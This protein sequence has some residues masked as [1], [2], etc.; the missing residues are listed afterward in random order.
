MKTLT[1]KVVFS[2]QIDV[3]VAAPALRVAPRPSCGKRA[4]VHP[5]LRGA[6][7]SGADGMIN[8]IHFFRLNRDGNK[9]VGIL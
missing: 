7:Q 4:K 3:Y 1:N 2:K 6:V 9:Y 8:P 5:H